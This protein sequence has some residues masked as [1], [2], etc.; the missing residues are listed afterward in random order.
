MRRIAATSFLALLLAVPACAQTPSTIDGPL[1]INGNLKASGT[2][3]LGGLSV[4]RQ[5]TLQGA[6]FLAPHLPSNQPTQHCA[7]WVN[8]GVLQRTVCP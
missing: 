6:L 1:T 3:T 8:N 5:L 4:E 7:L 2:S